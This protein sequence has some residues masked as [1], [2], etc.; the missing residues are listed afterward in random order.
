MYA[1]DPIILEPRRTAVMDQGFGK[2]ESLFFKKFDSGS[3]G[4]YATLP[5]RTIDYYREEKERGV[6]PLLWQ[7]VP[8]ILYRG[9][10]DVRDCSV[11]EASS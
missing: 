10:I 1:I 3:L 5:Q 2:D 8:H 11:V 9:E 4:E 6:S 7:Y